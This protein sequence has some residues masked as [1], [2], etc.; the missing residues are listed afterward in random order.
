MSIQHHNILIYT[1][2]MG[3]YLD[4]RKIQQA[5]PLETPLGFF[6]KNSENLLRNIYVLTI[7]TF[8]YL[9]Y[10]FSVL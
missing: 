2:H 7:I 5:S 3:E 10:D 9:F 8:N 4:R 6:V 1:H